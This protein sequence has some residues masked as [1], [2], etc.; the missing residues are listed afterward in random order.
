MTQVETNIFVRPLSGDDIPLMETFLYEA[1]FV[2]AGVT[3][4]PREI[5][6]QSELVMYVQILVR[7]CGD[8]GVVCELENTVVG[9]RGRASWRIMAISTTPHLRLRSLCCLSIVD[10]ESAQHY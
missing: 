6:K 8:H 1:I 9:M 3:K 7:S 10:A 2:P 4:P 5:V